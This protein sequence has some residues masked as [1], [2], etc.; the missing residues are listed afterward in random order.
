MEKV[1]GDSLAHYT[2]EWVLRGLR[3]LGVRQYFETVP[4]MLFAW[5]LLLKRHLGVSH[6]KCKLNFI[7]KHYKNVL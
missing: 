4:Q 7:V 2:M 1:Y 6:Y 3:E 5:Y